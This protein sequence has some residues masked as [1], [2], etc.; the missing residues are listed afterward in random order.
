MPPLPDAPDTPEQTSLQLYPVS[1]GM[2]DYHPALDV[3]TQ[4][5]RLTKVLA[6]VGAYEVPWTA[7]MGSRG[8]DE[9]NARLINWAKPD[10][11][12]DTLLYWVGHGW[13]DGRE[14]SLAHARSPTA[15][16]AVGVLPLQLS[17]AICS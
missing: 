7:P 10:Q 4:V 13:S 9:V 8:A 1:L 16:R 3:A 5:A 15:V 11:P 12:S 6:E 14:A 2:Y 17:D